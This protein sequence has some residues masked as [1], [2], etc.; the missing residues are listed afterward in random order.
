M[1]SRKSKNP[2][3]CTHGVTG[4]CTVIKIDLDNV[5]ILEIVIEIDYCNGIVLIKNVIYSIQLALIFRK[6]HFYQTR[7][8]ILWETHLLVNHFVSTLYSDSLYCSQ[9]TY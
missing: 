7:V 3:T 1:N 6:Q 8:F 4:I 5:S 9:S 2:K